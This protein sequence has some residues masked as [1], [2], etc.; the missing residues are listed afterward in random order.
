[1][2]NDRDAYTVSQQSEDACDQDGDHGRQQRIS[3]LRSLTSD[4]QKVPVSHTSPPPLSAP[5]RHR[6]V[7][8]W[9]S[10]GALVIILFSSGIFIWLHASE[11]R[12]IPADPMII[13]FPS[14]GISCPIEATWSPDGKSIAVLG[15][16]TCGSPQPGMNNPAITSTTTVPAGGMLTVYSATSGAVLRAIR[17]D[18]WITPQSLPSSSQYG[19]GQG[20]QVAY[21]YFH[22]LWAPDG[23]CAAVLFDVGGMDQH[24]AAQDYGGGLLLIHVARGAVDVYAQPGFLHD[25]QAVRESAISSPTAPS[26]LRWDVTTGAMDTLHVP[27]ALSYEWHQDGTLQPTQPLSRAP[28]TPPPTATIQPVGNPLGGARFSI[29]QSGVLTYASARCSSGEQ[30]AAHSYYFVFGTTGTSAWSPDGRFLYLSVGTLG[31]LPISADP[32]VDTLNGGACTQLGPAGKWLQLPVRDAGLANAI[33]QLNPPL[34]NQAL[35]AWSPDGT[36]LAVELIAQAPET[37]NTPL[38]TIY[39]CRTGKILTELTA[40]Q[41]GMQP[42]LTR[43]ASLSDPIWAPDGNRLL[44]LK[45]DQARNDYSMLV[46]GRNSPGAAVAG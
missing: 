42:D 46:F 38:V 13:H 12:P 33:R 10:I 45:V 30:P 16:S 23:Q 14:G 32:P 5:R 7:V 44:L 35:V 40:H 6:P 19:S 24:G 26:T 11:S 28:D 9:L 37:Q 39:D 25:Y 43:T 41:F 29:W 20:K 34:S 31:R 15:Y 1:M 36:H 17:L 3:A 4:Q 27:P 18:S 22:V 8:L 2:D 21:N